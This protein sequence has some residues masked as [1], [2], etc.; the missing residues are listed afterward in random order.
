MQNT[1]DMGIRISLQFQLQPSSKVGERAGS[2]KQVYVHPNCDRKSGQPA[3]QHDGWGAGSGADGPGLEYLHHHGPD[4]QP[5]VGSLHFS[6]PWLYHW[7]SWIVFNEWHYWGI[8]WV[9][10]WMNKKDPKQCREHSQW[11]INGSLTNFSRRK[12]QRERYGKTCNLILV[13]LFYKLKRFAG[14]SRVLMSV[15][16]QADQSS[17][18]SE[19]FLV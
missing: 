18:L 3:K 10:E 1:E 7:K 14:C 9:N 12:T 4:V 8:K 2:F 6:E 15:F 11:S 13:L 19:S 5:W 17:P 16:Q